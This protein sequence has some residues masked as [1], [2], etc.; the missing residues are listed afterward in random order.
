MGDILIVGSNSILVDEQKTSKE[1]FC[2]EL[3]C[4]Q[5]LP[6]LFNGLDISINREG[7]YFMNQEE[8]SNQLLVPK[9]EKAFKSQR[10]LG[11]D[12]GMNCRP[13]VCAA[14]QLIAPGHKTVSL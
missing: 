11:Q 3:Y 7:V 12:T 13:D 14:V 2:K 1:V 4:L 6:T 10:A 8:K 5:E 9:T